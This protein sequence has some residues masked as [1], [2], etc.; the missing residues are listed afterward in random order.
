MNKSKQ[1]KAPP[2]LPEEIT[3]EA[4]TAFALTFE[5]L[6]GLKGMIAWARTHRTIFYQAYAKLIPL[7]VT[8]HATVTVEDNS[9]AAIDKLC[10]GLMRLRDAREADKAQGI[11]R[12]EHG[13][14]IEDPERLTLE[15]QI[16][17]LQQQKRNATTPIIDV[18]P[19]PAAPLPTI[20]KAPPVPPPVLTIVAGSTAK[21]AAPK[22]AAPKTAA[23]KPAPLTPEQARERA[24]RPSS[25]QPVSTQPN[26]T[27]LYYE[28]MN[29]GGGRMWWGPV[30]D[31]R[32]GPP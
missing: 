10:D 11:F 32:G 26:S 7:Q 1:Q 6:G 13:A 28:W 5:G 3:T 31:E 25:P 29:N 27:R 2:P 14:I 19:S 23:K 17:D 18:T 21:P 22:P 9:T 24:T 8:S 12:D 30:G 16:Y 15:K 4:K 20:N